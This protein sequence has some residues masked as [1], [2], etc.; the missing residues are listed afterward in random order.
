MAFKPSARRKK[1]EGYKEPDLLVVMNLMVCLIP[2][3]LSCAEFVKLGNI[4]LVMPE[5][6]GGGGGSGPV[7]PKVETQKLMTLNV[8]ITEFGFTIQS[9]I[10]G[11]EPSVNGDPNASISVKQT[12]LPPE[13]EHYWSS[14][15]DFKSLNDKMVSLRKEAEAG[16]YSDVGNI[17]ITAAEGIKYQLVV[18]TIDAVRY[19]YDKD[20]EIDKELF[21]AVALGAAL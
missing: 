16:G 1:G 6:S 18:F 4:E 13:D 11:I 20:R 5:T 15:Y 14:K 12:N 7:D 8:L 9:T 3:L 17:Q 2:L 21:P 19:H 10:R